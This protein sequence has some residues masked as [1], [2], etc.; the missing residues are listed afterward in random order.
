MCPIQRYVK[1]HTEKHFNPCHAEQ[2]KMPHPPTS[3]FQ[4]IRLL[5]P[6]C[7]YKFKY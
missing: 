1:S 7:L 4:P 5:D 2:I 6:G 3:N